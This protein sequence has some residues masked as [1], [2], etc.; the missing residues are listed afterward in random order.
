MGGPVHNITL[1]NSIQGNAHTRVFEPKGRPLKFD[2]RRID[3]SEGLPQL[4]FSGGHLFSFRKPLFKQVNHRLYRY[5]KGP[6]ADPV[7]LQ[8]PLNH[9]SN[10]RGN[11]FQKAFPVEQCNGRCLIKTAHGP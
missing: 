8:C 11:V 9:L 7:I 6:V 3:Q 1:C 4:A 10:F 5:I 2:V